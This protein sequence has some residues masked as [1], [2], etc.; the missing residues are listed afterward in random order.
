[1]EGFVVV[2]IFVFIAVVIV[3]SIHATRR[4]NESWAQAAMALGL[5]Y[6]KPAMLASR[7]ISGDYKGFEVS[8]DTYTA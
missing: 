3:V 1:M 8:I 2:F 6:R 5:Y 7:R 4:V